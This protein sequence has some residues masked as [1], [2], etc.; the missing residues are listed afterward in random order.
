MIRVRVPKT[1]ALGV[2]LTGVGLAILLLGAVLGIWRSASPTGDGDPAHRLA[3]ELRCPAC[4]G[5]SVADSRSPIAAAMREAISTRLGRGE[6]PDEVRTYLVQRYGVEVLTMPPARRWGLL[7]WAVPVLAL[8]A[9]LLP[10]LRAG[11]RSRRA[12]RSASP[13]RPA[14]RDDRAGVRGGAAGD[15]AGQG[16]R[17]G[18]RRHRVFAPP[19]GSRVW[20]VGAVAV[21]ALVGAVALATPG[22]QTPPGPATSPDPVP[23]QL[24]LARSMEQQGQYEAAAEVYRTVLVERPADD[25][26]LRLAFILIRL[27]QATEAARL[28]GEVLAH[29]PDAPDGLLILGLAQRESDP[30]AAT[31]TLRRFL[32]RAPDHPAAAEVRRLVD[33]G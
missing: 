7:L 33:S 11:Y 12:A 24:A 26:R 25:V 1:T 17:A 28:A 2:G 29:T 16:R 3:A 23:A 31:A 14:G 18:S 5:E 20:N 32:T 4:Q 13:G 22:P 21:L 19:S 27:G 10:V 15:V 6:S 8:G 9:G 30:P